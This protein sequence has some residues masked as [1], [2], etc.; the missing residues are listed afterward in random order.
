MA[1]TQKGAGKYPL[2]VDIQQEAMWM[3]DFSSCSNFVTKSI[4]FVDK[5]IRLTQK[6]RL[7]MHELN[8][9]FFI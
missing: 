3:L 6:I 9:I 2:R 4:E 7:S 1:E 5:K 8:C